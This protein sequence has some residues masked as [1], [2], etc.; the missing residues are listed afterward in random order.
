MDPVTSS[1]STSQRHATSRRTFTGQCS[2]FQIVARKS[3]G[4]HSYGL[5]NVTKMTFKVPVSVCARLTRVCVFYILFIFH[6]IC[7]I[8][9][10]N[11]LKE[12]LVFVVYLLRHRCNLYS[13]HTTRSRRF[14]S[15]S[16][17][18]IF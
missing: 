10:Y 7:D 11:W 2:G 14:R 18:W 15:V 3:P 13:G 6:T 8:S 9:G 4:L 16:I 17:Y 12:C 1:G 5:Y